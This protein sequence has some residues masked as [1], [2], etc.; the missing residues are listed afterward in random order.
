M[1][2]IQD[3]IVPFR[4]H[5]P[6]NTLRFSVQILR[7]YVQNRSFH[8]NCL[9][10]LPI[11]FNTEAQELKL[12]ASARD[13]MV[14][15]FPVNLMAHFPNPKA[16]FPNPYNNEMP[17]TDAFII[18]ANNYFES[19]KPEFAMQCP[20]F[21][22]WVDLSNKLHNYEMYANLAGMVFYNEVDNKTKH[23]SDLPQ[24][25]VTMKSVND[26]K[27]PINTMDKAIA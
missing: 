21:F 13:K 5:I 16:F 8:F 17:P 7:L 27:I 4:E 19:K 22:D 23:A 11:L 25:V 15:T 6:S 18:R 2:S 12:E 1:S 3:V 26:L 24:L 20:F 10:L 14:N 9:F